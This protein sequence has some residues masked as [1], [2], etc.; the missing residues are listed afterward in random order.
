MRGF[1]PGFIVF[2]QDSLRLTEKIEG[3][4]MIQ[5]I[6]ALLL[7]GEPATGVM[8]DWLKKGELKGVNPPPTQPIE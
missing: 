4:I 3:I 5:L 8:T 7:R 6:F 1:V 2:A